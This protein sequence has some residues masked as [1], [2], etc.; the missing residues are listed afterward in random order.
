MAKE[1]IAALKDRTG[2]SNQAIKAYITSKYPNANFQQHLLRTALKKAATSGKFVMV[3]ALGDTMVF[4]NE[5][6][7]WGHF[8]DG[9]SYKAIP[10]AETRWYKEDLFGLKTVDEAGKIHFETTPGERR[11]RCTGR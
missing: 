1:A 7:H 3:K 4:P 6:E 9:T 2:S 10:M 11:K 8:E 5:G